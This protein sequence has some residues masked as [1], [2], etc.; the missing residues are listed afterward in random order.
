MKPVTYNIPPQTHLI[1]HLDS[2]YRLCHFSF[3][4][5]PDWYFP[6]LIP[7]IM[8]LELLWNRPQV[9]RELHGSILSETK[10]YTQPYSRIQ[11]TWMYLC[12]A[13]GAHSSV[14][15]CLFIE[16]S[17]LFSSQK[18]T[19][20]QYSKNNFAVSDIGR[21]GKGVPERAPPPL[22]SPLPRLDFESIVRNMHIL[23]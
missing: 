13:T 4:N 3:M 2:F 21:G 16:S 20:K 18:G 9:S 19:Q 23:H 7:F 22:P 15:H 6:R 14:L 17:H 10:V 1:S 5:L 12:E 8:S 11:A